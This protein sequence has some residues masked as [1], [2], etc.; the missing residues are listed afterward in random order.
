LG[1]KLGI[2]GESNLSLSDYIPVQIQLS[3]FPQLRQLAWQVSDAEKLNPME[4]WSIY[5]RNWRH[6]DQA[7]LTNEELQLIKALQQAVGGAVNV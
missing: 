2:K 1:L 7:A 4:A 3:N 6:I 5:E